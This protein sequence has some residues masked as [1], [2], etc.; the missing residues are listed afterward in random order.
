[1]CSV[2]WPCE[3]LTLQGLIRPEMLSRDIL[4]R[5]C[6][7][8]H[9]ASHRHSRKGRWNWLETRWRLKCL[10]F[11]IWIQA[12][13]RRAQMKRLCWTGTSTWGTGAPVAVGD[14]PVT[15]KT[16]GTWSPRINPVRCTRKECF[17]SIWEAE[18]STAPL[19]ALRPRRTCVGWWK[20]YWKS[21][22]PSSPTTTP[23]C[24]RLRP[25]AQSLFLDSPSWPSPT[26]GVT[27]HPAAKSEWLSASR[28][29]RGIP[30]LPLCALLFCIAALELFKNPVAFLLSNASFFW[31]LGSKTEGYA[32]KWEPVLNL[33]AMIW[34]MD[35]H[36][37]QLVFRAHLLHLL[38]VYNELLDI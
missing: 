25:P 9:A 7:Y 28:M 10:L 38:W 13:R 16:R 20:G 3:N 5:Y 34:T 29:C 4:C 12:L 26:S 6:T 23:M 1:M 36:F 32:S 11:R 8:A 31:A 14:S 21:T 24:T 37:E 17:L 35:F 27:G 18:A 15:A 33:K 2:I 19:W 30:S 22:G